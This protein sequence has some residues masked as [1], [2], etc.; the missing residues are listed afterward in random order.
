[1]QALHVILQFGGK[2]DCLKYFGHDENDDLQP[3]LQNFNTVKALSL[4]KLPKYESSYR[5]ATTNTELTELTIRYSINWRVL[6][7]AFEIFPSLRKISIHANS[8]KISHLTQEELGRLRENLNQLDRFTV[9][10]GL[11]SNLKTLKQFADKITD[12]YLSLDFLRISKSIKKVCMNVDFVSIEGDQGSNM[13]L[14]SNKILDCFPNLLTLQLGSNVF[15][16]FKPN[17]LEAIKDKAKNLKSLKL[18]NARKD[19]IRVLN[20]E[21]RLLGIDELSITSIDGEFDFNRVNDFN[22]N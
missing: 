17:L 20:Q 8:L 12:L 21:A 16:V 1:M 10:F 6:F 4:Y 2:V 13:S 22:F 7:G 15:D 18:K 19:L 5:S 11:Q 14:D 3:V 9:E